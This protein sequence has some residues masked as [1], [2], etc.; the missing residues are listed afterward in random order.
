MTHSTITPLSR[1][2]WSRDHLSAEVAGE[3]VLMSIER[4]AYYG[5]DSVGSGVW[6]ILSQPTRVAELCD[7]LA[8]IYEADRPT[9]EA[10]VLRFLAALADEGLIEVAADA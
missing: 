2:C 1:V 4:G 9:L 6:R 10:D 5:L 3:V 8:E 7:G